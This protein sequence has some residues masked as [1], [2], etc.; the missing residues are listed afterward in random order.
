MA[1]ALSRESW[2]LFNAWS[3]WIWTSGG[4]KVR[5]RQTKS[6][7]IQQP[8]LGILSSG[9][10]GARGPLMA[11]QRKKTRAEKQPKPEAKWR[12]VEKVV[13]FLEKSLSPKAQVRHNVTLPNL[14]TGHMEQ[15]DVMI[16]LGPQPRIKR[17]V[18][19]VQKRGKRVQVNDFRGWCQKFREVGAHQLICVSAEPF[20]DSIKDMVT[21]ELGPTVLL[22][23]L[24]DLAT[25]QWPI[26]IVNNSMRVFNPT[27]DIDS[28]VRPYFIFPANENPFPQAGI[29]INCQDKVIRRD[30]HEELFS[31]QHLIDEGVKLLNEHPQFHRLPEGSHNFTH[32]WN[33]K[34]VSLCLGGIT[35]RI[36]SFKVGY[37]ITVVSVEFPF[38]I[39]SYEQE[40][41]GG[42]L[43]WVARAVGR[44]DGNDAEIRF[45]L[46]PESNGCF[47]MRAFQ[48]IGIK[49]GC[50][51]FW[52]PEPEK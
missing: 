42:S 37:R 46:I 38:E 34:G 36:E 49:E 52:G 14:V 40:G 50:F 30:G 31:V 29:E 48:V 16:E 25:S 13:A 27:V 18:V 1:K 51:L 3:R 24:Q 35:G 12:T 47:S 44:I 41:H 45:S 15:F 2:R 33:P 43:A 21:K 26:Q 8:R 4:T 23:R 5:G 19:E 20:P 6:A 22:V 28:S 10:H 11:K 9:E 7:G 39:S 17:T 32:R